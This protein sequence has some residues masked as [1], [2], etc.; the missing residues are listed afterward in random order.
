MKRGREGEETAEG[1]NVARRAAKVALQ[2]EVLEVD[3]DE[4]MQLIMD[5]VKEV[6]PHKEVAAGLPLR[7]C[8]GDQLE[9]D[10]VC[11]VLTRPEE[12]EPEEQ[13]AARAKESKE[14]EAHTAMHQDE[15]TRAAQLPTGVGWTQ[16]LKPD[17]AAS[18]A[19]MFALIKSVQHAC[20]ADGLGPW[21]ELEMA[22]RTFSQQI[23]SICN[24]ATAESESS[25]TGAED[26]CAGRLL[27]LLTECAT[28]YLKGW[29]RCA[30]ST[31]DACG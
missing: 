11:A 27:A 19:S 10:A 4:R 2:A 8:D 24:L 23:G 21:A 22:C 28:K 16:T 15:A 7:R 6:R 29:L 13:L 20:K 18:V 26:R 9:D 31:H 30:R 5:S 3:D 1:G 17:C 14:A 25:A 12:S